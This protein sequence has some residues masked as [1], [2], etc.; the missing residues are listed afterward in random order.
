MHAPSEMIFPLTAPVT[1]IRGAHGY[2]AGAYTDGGET[3]GATFII[4]WTDGNS[5]QLLYERNIDPF[6]DPLDQGLLEFNLEDLALPA[7]GEIRFLITINENPGWDWTA[8]A[9]ITLE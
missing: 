3:D 8:W 6:N 5:E 7:N 4:K 9:G 2:P 1:S